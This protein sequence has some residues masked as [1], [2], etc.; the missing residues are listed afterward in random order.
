[1]AFER[2]EQSKEYLN[3]KG[4]WQSASAGR[5]GEAQDLRDER[6]WSPSEHCA[7]QPPVIPS[8]NAS[9]VEDSPWRARTRGIPPRNLKGNFCEI[10]RLR[11]G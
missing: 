3:K 2:W 6:I 8:V 10:P 1:M 9:P 5:V 7:C 4:E 11:S